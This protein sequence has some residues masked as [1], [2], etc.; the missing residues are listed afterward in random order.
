M[1][2]G[3]SLPL[4]VDAMMAKAR[5]IAGVDFVDHAV[6]EPLTV[7]HRS[8]CEEAQLTEKGALAKQNRLLSMMANRLRMQRDFAHHPEIAAEK[9]DGPLIVCGMARSG[10]TKTQKVLAA[11]GDFNWL[12]YW[13]CY[14]PSSF[15][16]QPNENT[17]ARIA[18]AD[19]YCRWFAEAS[20]EHVSGHAFETFE[21]EEDTVLTEHSFV[22]PAFVGYGFVPSYL[23]WLGSQPPT[24]LFEYLRDLLKYLQ[25]QGLASASKRWL[26][27]APLYNGLELEILKV[28]PD[29]HFVMTHRSPLQTLP[30]SC[31]LSACFTLPFSNAMPPWEVISNGFVMSLS[32]HLTIRKTHPELPMLDLSFD[33]VNKSMDSAIEKIYAHAGMSL[34]EASRQRMRQWSID[35]PMHKNGPFKYSLEEFGLNE[36]KIKQDMAGY[37]DLL[38][39]L[40]DKT[41]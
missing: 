29:A 12:P 5:E 28:F 17:D 33:E 9:I 26:L 40:F 24:L 2:R 3:Y 10:T 32:R 16:G 6:V 14:N 35:H 31:K 39:T 27:K 23:Q 13:Q 18:E 25:W 21:A 38:K 41:P 7:L 19:A 4:S 20:P 1:N 8:L 15:T 11:S 22:T 30:S 37:L 34:S 36:A